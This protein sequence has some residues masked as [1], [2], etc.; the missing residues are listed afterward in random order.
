MLFAEGMIFSDGVAITGSA[1][2]SEVDVD[3]DDLGTG[4]PVYLTV[5]VTEDFASVAEDETLTVKLQDKTSGSFGD[6][7]MS[8]K[9][10][11]LSDL[12]AGAI[13]FRQ[14]LPF[15]GDNDFR[16]SYVVAGSG[17][18]TAGKVTAGLTF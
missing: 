9:A 5:K 6:T 8:S 4:K 18:F 3:L 1:V 16:L 13:V 12:K 17:N 14:P 15:K 11:A 7:G 2:S 10:I